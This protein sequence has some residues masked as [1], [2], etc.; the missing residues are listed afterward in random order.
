VL[1]FVSVGMLVDPAIVLRDPLPLLAT[2]LIIVIGK[3]LAAF[4]IVRMFGHPN[5]TALT[6][7]A[8]LAQI[9]EFSF[10]LVTLGVSLALLPE[11][12]K[13][14]VLAGAI[15]SIVLNPVLFVLLD[16]YSARAERL[17]PKRKRPQPAVPAPPPREPLPVSAKTDHVVLVGYGRVGSVVG[18]RLLEDD[19]PLVV[20]EDRPAP[21]K[22]LREKGVE[23]LQGNA[24]AQGVLHAAN[25]GAARA[26]LVA[27]PD[28][29]EGGQ[30]IAKA[31]AFSKELPI[32]ARAHSEQEVAHLKHH[33]ANLVIM[34][35]EEIAKAM[36]AQIM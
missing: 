21:V 23:V 10:I 18:R 13:D 26:L 2:L 27:I 24:V 32:I 36:I 25:L 31:R 29:F 12:G 22:E 4:L 1:F 16:K 33:G 14:L 28:A 7:S 34:G 5:V 19:T 20:I 9:G 8:S 11:R 30:I 3:S 15:V 6:I 35:E 17:A